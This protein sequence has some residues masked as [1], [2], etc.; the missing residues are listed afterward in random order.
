MLIAEN[1]GVVKSTIDDFA[2]G[3]AEFA[4]LVCSHSRC[5]PLQ[6]FDQRH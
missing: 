1:V 3:L 5:L 2:G 6:F 4:P